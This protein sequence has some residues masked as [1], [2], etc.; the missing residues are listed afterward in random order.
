MNV[1]LRPIEYVH[2]DDPIIRE[3][4]EA[5][6][7][8]LLMSS[9]EDLPDNTGRLLH[10]KGR[11]VSLDRDL[12]DEGVPSLRPFAPESAQ[13]LLRHLYDL[14]HRHIGCFNTQPHDAE[15]EGRI[16]QRR[17][18]TRAH[19]VQA[20]LI[21]EPVKPYGDARAHARSTLRKLIQGKGKGIEATALFCTTM[22]TAAGAMRG[23]RELGRWA[24]GNLSICSMN[25]EGW[26]EYLEPTLTCLN[27]PDLEP[28]LGMCMEWM[29]SGEEWNGSILIQPADLSVFEGDSTGVPEHE[30]SQATAALASA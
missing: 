20:E 14:G 19:K 21:D 2:W 1:S 27:I 29:L 25:G 3:T 17:L 26:E 23:L 6:E 9:A 7:G 13:L 16:E 4:L 11:V 8:V 24:G 5:Y 15:V 22:A 30:Y 10:E 12:S 28:Y 18:W